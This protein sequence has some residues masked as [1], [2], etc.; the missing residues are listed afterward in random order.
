[1]DYAYACPMRQVSF[2]FKQTINICRCKRHFNQKITFDCLNFDCWLLKN[3][4]FSNAISQKF[5][6][7]RYF[8]NNIKRRKFIHYFEFDWCVADTQRLMML[9]IEKSFKLSYIAQWFRTWK[10]SIKDIYIFD[11]EI[12]WFAVFLH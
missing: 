1:M 12:I 6:H 3:D 4:F 10:N 11:N 7:C 5:Y 8:K 2:F 9:F